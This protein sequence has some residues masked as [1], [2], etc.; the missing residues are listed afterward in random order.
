MVHLLELMNLPT[1]GVILMALF[2]SPIWGRLLRKCRQEGLVR[3][4]QEG[5][6]RVTIPRCWESQV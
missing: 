5:P 1:R 6:D 4:W 3:E 2:R